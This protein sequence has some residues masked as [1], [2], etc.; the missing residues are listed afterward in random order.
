MKGGGESKEY[1]LR[2]IYWGK[3]EGRVGFRINIAIKA[4]LALQLLINHAP[5]KNL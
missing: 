3:R 1:L 2:R 5:V 4:G